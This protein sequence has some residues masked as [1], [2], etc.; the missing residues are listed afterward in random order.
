MVLHCLYL[1]WCYTVTNLDGLTLSLLQM[2]LHCHYFTGVTL[3]LLR[4]VLHCLYYILWYTVSASYVVTLSLLQMVLH[5]L[6]FR[7]CYTVSTS[8]GVILVVVVVG[9]TVG[10]ISSKTLAY[11]CLCTLELCTASMTVSISDGVTLSLL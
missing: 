8:D 9:Q 11:D 6:N 3:S 4:M 1:R 5:C 10:S 7:W 2:V